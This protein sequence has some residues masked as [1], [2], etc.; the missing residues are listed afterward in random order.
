MALSAAL[1]PAPET[2]LDPVF[3]PD[4]LDSVVDEPG[5]GQG[6]YAC[7]GEV[8]GTHDLPHVLPVLPKLEAAIGQPQAPGIG[9]D[10]G[11]EAEL[12]YYNVPQQLESLFI[13]SIGE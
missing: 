7:N 5:H 6:Y 12:S 8:E 11:V 1:L 13:G 4:G 9:P 2:S 3:V 10:E